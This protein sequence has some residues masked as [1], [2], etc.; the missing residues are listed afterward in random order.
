MSNSAKAKS[1]TQINVITERFCSKLG[2]NAIIVTTRTNQGEEKRC[3]YS[4]KCDAECEH[5]KNQ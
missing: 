5:K 1:N 3:L 2:D 4:D